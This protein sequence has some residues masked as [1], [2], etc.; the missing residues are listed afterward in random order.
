MNSEVVLGAAEAEM[1]P[2]RIFPGITARA[3]LASVT[4]SS[5]GHARDGFGGETSVGWKDEDI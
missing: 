4:A 5:S 1:S 2:F 3:V